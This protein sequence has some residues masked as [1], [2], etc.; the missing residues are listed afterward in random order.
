MIRDHQAGARRLAA[1]VTIAA[2]LLEGAWLVLQAVG[3]AQR[4]VRL[5]ADGM[6]QTLAAATMLGLTFPV[7]AWVIIRRQ[8]TNLVGWVFLAVGSWQA[9]NT[10]AYGYSTMAFVWSGRDLPLAAELSWLAI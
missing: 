2:I 4:W 9:L 6:A 7:V 3:V 8:P 1:V 10:F 5:E